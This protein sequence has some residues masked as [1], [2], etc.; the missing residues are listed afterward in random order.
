MRSPTQ[1]QLNNKLLVL[2]P[3]G[4]LLQPNHIQLQNLDLMVELMPIISALKEAKAAYY[5]LYA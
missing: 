3:L 2:E 5:Q 1:P 4:L